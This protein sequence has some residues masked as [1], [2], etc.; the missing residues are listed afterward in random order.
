MR[1]LV[2]LRHGKTVTSV[3]AGD[4]ARHLAP[5][6]LS[7]AVAAGRR[8]EELA[9]ADFALVSDARR[10]RETF[11]RLVEATGRAIA[12]RFE[13][14]LY[15]ATAEEI[16]SLV[17]S[18]GRGVGTLLVVGHNP[19]IGDLARRL[20]LK[21]SAREKRE[22]EARFPTSALA[23]LDLDAAEW[24]GAGQGGTLAAL[25]MPNDD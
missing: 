19:G 21:A 20:A 7:E 16:A 10:T 12:H 15:G 8:I 5:R 18:T 14:R 22:L 24:S 1:R 6:G 17:Q 3:A 11:D 25:V 4:H 23:V 2:L 13:P 9:P